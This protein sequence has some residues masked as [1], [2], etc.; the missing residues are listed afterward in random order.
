MDIHIDVRGFFEIHAWLCYGFS[1]QGRW[2]FLPLGVS[3]DG[4]SY[5]EA[6]TRPNLSLPDMIVDEARHEENTLI[7]QLRYVIS[8]TLRH[9]GWKYPCNVHNYI[10]AKK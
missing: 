7:T 1:D 6:S 8:D 10:D 9:P 5:N 4:R 2:H 3:F